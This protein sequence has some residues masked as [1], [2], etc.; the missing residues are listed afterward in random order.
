MVPISPVLS[1][2]EAAFNEAEEGTEQVVTRYSTNNFNLHKP[3]LQIIK[4]AGLQ[5]WPK[6]IQNLK[7]SCETEW[8]DSEM[9]AHVVAAWIG[10]SVKVQNDSYA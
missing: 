4:N 5:P 7:A 8:L 6:L 3:F 10:H 9:P 1:Y 2:L